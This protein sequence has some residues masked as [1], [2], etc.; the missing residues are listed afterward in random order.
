[1]S[2]KFTK[3]ASLTQAVERE[4]NVS[5]F[6][7]LWLCPPLQADIGETDIQDRSREFVLV[8]VRE[9]NQSGIGSDIVCFK[10]FKFFEAFG[11]R[12]YRYRKLQRA[13]WTA[14]FCILF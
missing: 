3:L 7:T 1:M 2:P 9:S 8:F 14:I 12:D 6:D 5:R 13:H 11:Y 10:S 4:I